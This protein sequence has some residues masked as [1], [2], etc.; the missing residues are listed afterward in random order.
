M[1]NVYRL[2]QIRFIVQIRAPSGITKNKHDYMTNTNRNNA[3]T[4]THT[5]TIVQRQD[6]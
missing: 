5:I 2:D 6:A 4:N 3:Y 1:D